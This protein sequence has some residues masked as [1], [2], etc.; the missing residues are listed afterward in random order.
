M[1]DK[2]KNH[3]RVAAALKYNLGED[4]A[5]KVVAAGRG[6]V[7]KK[8]VEIANKENIPI[9]RD[10]VLAQALTELGIG[11]EIPPE[12][13]QAVAKILIQ[14]ARLDKKM[15]RQPKTER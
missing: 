10:K 4:S 7:A 12:L 5:P 2:E 13:Y 15:E 1:Q 14:V 3:T 9:H 6:A 11:V 8:I